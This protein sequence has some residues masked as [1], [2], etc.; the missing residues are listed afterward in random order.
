MPPRTLVF[1][2]DGTLVDSVPDLAAA[3]NRMMVAHAVEPFSRPET[4]RMVGDGTLALAQRAFEA[5]GLPF[6]QA[7]YDA[8]L[9]DYTAH[10]AVATAVLGPLILKMI[11]TLPLAAFTINRG[12][13]NGLTRLTPLARRTLFCSSRVSIPPIPLPMITPQRWESSLVKSMAASL[14]AVNEAAMP[15]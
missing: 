9:A 12:T 10:A 2:L 1:D 13:V 4:T 6:D 5:R 11:E 7:G 14:T 8:F 3:L 15:N